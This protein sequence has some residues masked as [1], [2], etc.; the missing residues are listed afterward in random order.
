M[1]TASDVADVASRL[2]FERLKRGLPG[3]QWAEPVVPSSWAVEV[4]APVDGDWF[5]DSLNGGGEL[6]G[7]RRGR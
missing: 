5:R 1:P 4:A 3:A 6:R 2:E 7:P